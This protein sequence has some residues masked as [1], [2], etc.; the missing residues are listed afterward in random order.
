MYTST[1]SKMNI[2]ASK[3]IIDGIAPD[4][5][6]FVKKL[7]KKFSHEDLVRLSKLSYKELAFEIMKLFF[8]DF[9]EKALKDLIEKAYT[10]TFDNLTKSS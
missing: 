8:N 9:E 4:G 6:L 2:N 1:R 10:N 3:A 5:G 7:E